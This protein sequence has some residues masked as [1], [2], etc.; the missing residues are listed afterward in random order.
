LEETI[1]EARR[2][3]FETGLESERNVATLSEKEFQA[4][5]GQGA[6]LKRQ[7]DSIQRQAE[8]QRSLQAKG[9]TVSSREFDLDRIL[10]DVEVKQRDL[11]SRAF[12]A[13]QAR[14][15]AEAAANNAENRR[16]EEIASELQQVQA[17]LGELWQ[18]AQTVHAIATEAERVPSKNRALTFNIVRK[19][20]E[21]GSE[22]EIA[23][24]ESTPIRPGD[25]LRVHFGSDQPYSTGPGSSAFKP[26]TLGGAPGGPNSFAG[27]AGHGMTPLAR[28]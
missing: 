26:G 24:S 21:G 10:A 12:R 25:V 28:F 14:G 19:D 2:R 9:L 8:N 11:E 22:T 4:L 18:Q 3:V 1:F 16:R 20:L 13:Q 23:A 17:K 5:Q 15:R 7:E 27:P 6:S